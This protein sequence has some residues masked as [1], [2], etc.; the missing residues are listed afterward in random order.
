[1]GILIN[2]DGHIAPTASVSVLDRG[3][4]YGDNVYEVVRTYQGRP[5]A[6]QEHVDR[7]RRSA[8][9]LYLEI[10]WFDDHICTEVKRTIAAAGKG[11]YYIRI[12]VSR[13][14]DQRI[15]LLPEPQTRPRLLII[16]LP[17]DSHPQLS[18]T[19]LSLEISQRERV[20]R[21][22]LDPAAKTGNYL[23]NILALV[24]AQRN[25]KDDALLLNNA[26]QI[27]EATT[28]NL[29]I[30][31]QGIIE[32]PVTDVGILHG[33]TRSVLLTILERLGLPHRQV[34]LR[35]EDLATATEAF[36]SS[37]VR[38]LM[39]IRELGVHILPECPGPVTRRLW[40]EL[41]TVMARQNS[42]S[43]L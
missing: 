14:A 33:I 40:Q 38:L 39:P 25:G 8:E 23:N 37:S 19:G 6:L 11:D 32:T 15:S 30:V 12:V 10:P 24:E 42:D 21:N 22:A 43:L 18:E 20:S 16:L 1:M 4:L 36:L 13:G 41:L 34:F 31:R 2:L 7:L 27:T 29:W 17:V 28:S 5:F 9:Y 3:F 35:P 26:G